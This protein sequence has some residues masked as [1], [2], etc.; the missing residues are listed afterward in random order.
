MFSH[1]LIFNSKKHMW[2]TPYKDTHYVIIHIFCWYFRSTN[3]LINTLFDED[4]SLRSK[5]LL[6]YS[7]LSTHWFSALFA[8]SIDFEPCYKPSAYKRSLPSFFE[9][10][11]VWQELALSLHI[12]SMS[13]TLYIKLIAKK[14]LN[15]I[16]CLLHFKLFSLSH[17][18]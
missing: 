15:L 11:S 10:S 3:W 7:F 14:L 5:Y 9:H 16:N 12:L 1:A 6:Q 18:I 4:N 17:F 8:F 13:S 2:H